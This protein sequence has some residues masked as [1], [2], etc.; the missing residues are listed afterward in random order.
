MENTKIAN[1]LSAIS[2]IVEQQ[3]IPTIY[4]LKTTYAIV[5]IEAEVERLEAE[6]KEAENAYTRMV[7]ASMIYNSEEN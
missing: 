2:Q 7:G 6:L 3:E 5:A 4:K 1:A